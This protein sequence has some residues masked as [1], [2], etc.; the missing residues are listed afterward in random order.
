MVL[1]NPL[2]NE[3]AKLLGFL[4]QLLRLGFRHHLGVVV[5]ENVPLAPA[6]IKVACEVCNACAEGK[7]HG[8]KGRL[9][10]SGPNHTVSRTGNR[11]F[12]QL[13]DGIIGG[14]KL[15]VSGEARNARILEVS[16][17][18]GPEALKFSVAC[19]VCLHPVT[20]E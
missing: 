20:S 6:R 11:H 10:V 19:G 12:G 14:G 4:H 13:E 5:I 18:N 16:P 8:F 17:D 2:L 15:A 9:V 1:C 7:L 3:C